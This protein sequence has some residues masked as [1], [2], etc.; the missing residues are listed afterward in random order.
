[1]PPDSIWTKAEATFASDLNCVLYVVALV[2]EGESKYVILEEPT[3]LSVA[4]AV[5]ALPK[6]VDKVVPPRSNLNAQEVLLVLPRPFWVTITRTL[7]VAELGVIV[8]VSV[9]SA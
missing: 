6:V 1:M 3:T 4:L 7:L 2:V 5:S 8:A 9:V